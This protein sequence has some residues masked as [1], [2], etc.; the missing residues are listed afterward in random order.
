M[1]NV[2]VR[3]K[4]NN[5]LMDIIEN[6]YNQGKTKMEPVYLM[7]KNGDTKL[8][9]DEY[10][11]DNHVGAKWIRPD[12]PVLSAKICSSNFIYRRELKGEELVRHALGVIKDSAS[13]ECYDCLLK[14]FNC[15]ESFHGCPKY[16]VIPERKP[17]QRQQDIAELKE[18]IV[19]LQ[20]RICAME[21]DD[22]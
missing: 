5:D 8:I 19:T 1:E 16:M 22:K 15:C 13:G 17:D 21:N 14:K 18:N 12:A 2:Q 20:M 11:I 7:L 9:S 10:A 3:G 4:M 6:H